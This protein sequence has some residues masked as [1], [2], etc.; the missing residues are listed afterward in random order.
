MYY[1]C[2]IHSLINENLV[3]F[4]VLAIVNAATLNIE[5]HISF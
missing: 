3:C 5:V 4:H 2:F 1:I